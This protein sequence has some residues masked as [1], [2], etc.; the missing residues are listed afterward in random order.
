M[1]IAQ[2]KHE[3]T[4]VPV[5]D[6]KVSN[7]NASEIASFTIYIDPEKE[8]AAL[9]KF[10]VYLL[11]VSVVFLVLSALDRNNLGNARVFG[12][13]KDIGLKGDEFGNITLL[14][15]LCTIVFE[16]P[17]V[18]AVKRFGAN[19]SLG[20]ALILWSCCTLGTAFIQNYGQAIAV[21]ML[22]NTFEAGLAQS[23]AYL[24][25]TIYPRERIGKRIMTTNLAMC[26][27]GAFGGLFAYSVQ[28]MGNQRGLAAWRWLFI[29]EFCITVLVGGIGWIL[30][31]TSAEKA[32]FL[33]EEEQKTMRLKRQR[34]FVHR[35]EDNFDPKWVKFALTDPFIWFL[36]TGFFTSSVAINGFGVFCPTIIAGLGFPSL[37]VNYLTVPIYVLGAISLITQVYYSDKLNKRGVFIVGSCIPVAVGYL[38]CIFTA[39]TVAGNAQ[40][41]K[42]LAEGATTNGLEGDM[43]LDSMYIL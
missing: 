30:L 6:T 11:P 32:W 3:T 41:A 26:I 33:S 35:G 21:R 34:D 27:S 14:S 1:N 16:V 20:T 9:R 39:N 4:K 10:D 28:T 29:I 25:S 42:L 17:W 23:F 22:L 8:S 18:L 31:P 12:F 7:D 5:V 38:I 13:D 37:Q 2:M 40:K 36:G 19:K 24:F 15:S 43:S